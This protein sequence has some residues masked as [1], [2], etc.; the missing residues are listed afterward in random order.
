MAKS[1][2][3]NSLRAEIEIIDQQILKLIQDRIEQVQKI[4]EL[5]RQLGILVE[6]PERESQLLN[7]YSIWQPGVPQEYLVILQ[8]ALLQISYLEHQKRKSN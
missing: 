7:L 8:K 6:D 5:K 1:K 2:Q 4:A 3:L